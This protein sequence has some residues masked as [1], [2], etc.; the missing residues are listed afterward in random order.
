MWSINAAIAATTPARAPTQKVVQTI[1]AWGADT[2]ATQSTGGSGGGGGRG[3]EGMLRRPGSAA[4]PTTAS[5]S[6]GQETRAALA[7]LSRMVSELD[8]RR[9]D[10]HDGSAVEAE[11][12]GGEDE[13]GGVTAHFLFNFTVEAIRREDRGGAEEGKPSS[14]LLHVDVERRVIEAYALR[15]GGKGGGNGGGTGGEPAL[16]QTLVR[17]LDLADIVVVALPEE[18]DG[19]AAAVHRGRGRGR[20]VILAEAAMAAAAG[21]GLTFVHVSA[22]PEPFW[23]VSRCV[24]SL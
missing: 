22:Q 17:T 16:Q 13:G 18:R 1:N 12:R 8:G 9:D 5:A 14:L 10:A 6:L 23:S 24:S 20:R 4:P 11:E 15:R 7:A 2:F 19:A 3:T 21:A